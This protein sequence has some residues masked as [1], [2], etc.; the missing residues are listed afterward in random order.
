MRRTA[1]IGHSAAAS[2]KPPNSWRHAPASLHQLL[3]GP[4]CVAVEPAPRH[5]RVQTPTRHLRPRPF[6]DAAERQSVLLVL[7]PP[8][9]ATSIMAATINCK[10]NCNLM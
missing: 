8:S 9:R 2:G 7:A 6:Q 5:N 10:Q 1:A 3:V 4:T